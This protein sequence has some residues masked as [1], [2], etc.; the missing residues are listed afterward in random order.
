[1]TVTGNITQQGKRNDIGIVDTKSYDATIRA[2]AE[3]DGVGKGD[4][5]QALSHAL[6]LEIV[7]QSRVEQLWVSAFGSGSGY[8]EVDGGINLDAL[9]EAA[10]NAL[11]ALEG[12]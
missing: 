5:I 7:N 10:L 12:E 9:A 11:R 4:K 8:I 6:G 1:M 3:S 2:A